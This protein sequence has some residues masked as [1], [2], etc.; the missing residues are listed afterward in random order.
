MI[1][2]IPQSTYVPHENKTFIC[3]TMIF[4]RITIKN[5]ASAQIHRLI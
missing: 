5:D 4:G 1:A 3:G 2:K